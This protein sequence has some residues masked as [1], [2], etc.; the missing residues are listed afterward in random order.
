MSLKFKHSCGDY[1]SLK[2]ITRRTLTTGEVLVEASEKLHGE[3]LK[4]TCLTYQ[5][6]WGRK[7]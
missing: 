4:S 5:T 1:N 6:G 3:L 2:G 7:C